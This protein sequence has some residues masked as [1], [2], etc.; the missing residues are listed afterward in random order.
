MPKILFVDDEPL[1]VEFIVNRIKSS[2]GYEVIY[3]KTIGKAYTEITNR[4][5]RIDA[6]ILDLFM[7][8]DK[9]IIFT[10]E[11]WKGL[12][13]D[14]QYT[15]VAFYNYL[16]RNNL[17]KYVPVLILTNRSADEIDEIKKYF[18]IDKHDLFYTMDKMQDAPKRIMSK[19]EEMLGDKPKGFIVG[20]DMKYMDIKRKIISIGKTLKQG[21]KNE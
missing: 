19:L 17:L 8:F 18:R 15:G 12:K 21:D 13:V 6:I 20:V 16:F 4:D 14:T 9:N 2:P 10:D 3:S 11:D 5:N 1:R 7:P